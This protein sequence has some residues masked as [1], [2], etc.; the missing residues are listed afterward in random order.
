MADPAERFD[1]QKETV[2]Q[3]IEQA[4]KAY[5]RLSVVDLT[6]VTRDNATEAYQ[7]YA[8]IEM[9]FEAVGGVLDQIRKALEDAGDSFTDHLEQVGFSGGAVPLL[10]DAEEDKE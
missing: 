8:E 10:G 3:Q 9:V 7:E 6:N 4:I 5:Q 2:R 1:E